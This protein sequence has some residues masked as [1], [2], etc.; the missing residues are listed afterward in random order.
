[1]LEKISGGLSGCKLELLN[2]NI[3]RKFSS[4]ETYNDRLSKQIDKQILFSNFI[5][6]GIDT[7]KIL[8]VSY[9]N[10]YNFDMEYIHGVSFYDYF[11]TANINDIKFVVYTLFNYFDFFS[12]NYREINIQSKLLNK[13][14]DLE[15]KTLYP[16]YLKFLK[17]YTEQNKI[18][19]PKTFCHGDLTFSNIIFHK[20]RLFLVDFLDSYVDSFLCDLVKLKQDLYYLWSLEVQEKSNMRVNQI[21]SYIWNCL[22]NKYSQYI[23]TKEFEILDAIN[24][25]RIEPYLTSSQQRSILDIIVKSSKLYANFN[26]SY[27]GTV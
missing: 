14:L 27:G 1:M 17:H 13:I 24:S 6:K 18:I 2:D 3:L 19:V 16:D 12:S 7:P 22:S 4:S 11:L 20:N 15:K 10:L 25:L 9:K 21:Y 8:N 23:N 26:N 5:L